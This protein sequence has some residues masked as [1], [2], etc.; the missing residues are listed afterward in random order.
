MDFLL[1][2]NDF[3]DDE[4]LGTAELPEEYYEEEEHFSTLRSINKFKNY[5]DKEPEFYGIS[6]I[7]DVV[8]LDI[9]TNPSEVT[10]PKNFKL[11]DYHLDLMEDIF[12]T[13]FSYKASSDTYH[14]IV[15]NILRINN[16]S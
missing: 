10:I 3:S 9:M 6:R 14:K 13:V 1:S 8:L 16:N 11:S 7:S 2:Q 4:D 5:I 12:E 15:S